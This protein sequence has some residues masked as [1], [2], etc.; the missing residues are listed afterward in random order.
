MY[1]LDVEGGR[2]DHHWVL[3]ANGMLY[4][5]LYGVL[6]IYVYMS[7]VVPVYVPTYTRMHDKR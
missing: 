3:H 6:C 2:R 5:A 4:V 1:D 7:A